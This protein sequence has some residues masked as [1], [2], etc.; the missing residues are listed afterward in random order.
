MNVITIQDLYLGTIAAIVKGAGYHVALQVVDSADPNVQRGRLWVMPVKTTRADVCVNFEFREAGVR[1]QAQFRDDSS[2][3]E[4]VLVTVP[5]VEGIDAW[6]TDLIDALA[7]RKI[8]Y[9]KEAA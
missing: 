4:N 8:T 9:R 1:M 7:A 2:P 6:A 3:I 5:Y